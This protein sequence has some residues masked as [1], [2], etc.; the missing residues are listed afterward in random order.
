MTGATNRRWN[1]QGHTCFW[2][3]ADAL[4]WTPYLAYFQLRSL[5]FKLTSV[6]FVVYHF[7]IFFYTTLAFFSAIF[8]CVPLWHFLCTTLAFFVA[9]WT[10]AA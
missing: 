9:I 1:P 4:P 10:V 2:N 5:T 8:V 6:F 7:G 3:L